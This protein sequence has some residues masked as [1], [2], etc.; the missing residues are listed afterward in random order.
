MNLSRVS[1]PSKTGLIE[2][3]L[4][5]WNIECKWNQPYLSRSN[6]CNLASGMFQNN[7]FRHSRG[8]IDFCI[9]LLCYT[10]SQFKLFLFRYKMFIRSEGL[11]SMYPDIYCNI[12]NLFRFSRGCK[13]GKFT[14]CWT[15]SSPHF[16]T[17]DKNWNSGWTVCSGF[18]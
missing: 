12:C 6:S 5:S 11:R 15:N 13:S 9:Y 4:K 7:Q 17:N 10:S 1:K 2:R 14:F 16:P 8:F 3:R 18:R